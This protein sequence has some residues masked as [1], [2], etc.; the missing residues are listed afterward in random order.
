MPPLVLA[1]DAVPVAALGGA[2]IAV[3]VTAPDRILAGCAAL[4]ARRRGVVNGVRRGLLLMGF[5][6]VGG[7]LKKEVAEG[8][9]YFPLGATCARRRPDL[10][11]LT[12]LPH[13]EQV[14]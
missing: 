11:T 9:H 10:V 4:G 3:V 13:V 6:H 5:V 1:L 7:D 8:G 12:R 2:P 14:A